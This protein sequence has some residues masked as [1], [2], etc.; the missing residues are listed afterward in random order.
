M[1]WGVRKSR[2]S[3]LERYRRRPTKAPPRSL[4]GTMLGLAS[5]TALFII[6]IVVA[7]QTRTSPSADH[8]NQMELL[9][10]TQ[11]RS[12]GTPH[13]TEA[14]GSDSQRDEASAS[15]E[16]LPTENVDA[17]FETCGA[18]RITCVV[19]GDTFWLNRQK[20]RIADIDTPEISQPQCKGEYD[21]GMAAKARLITLLNEGPFE[22]RSAGSRDIDKYGRLLR[23]VIRNEV[24]IG[25]QLV[26]EGLAHRW[27][28][29]KQS[30]C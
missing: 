23:L 16:Q 9:A 6:A 17:R 15:T 13:F 1:G 18:I 25:E 10:T 4:T 20:I 11:N 21:L 19:D 22:L 30:W 3:R 24:S 14:R 12:P 8:K 2:P 28:G 7:F 29:Y 26:K 27:V 5:F